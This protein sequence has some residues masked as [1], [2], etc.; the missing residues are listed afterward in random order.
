MPKKAVWFHPLKPPSEMSANVFHITENYAKRYKVKLKINL[1][2][3]TCWLREVDDRRI[4]YIHRIYSLLCLVFPII[5]ISVFSPAIWILPRRHYC[6][7]YPL[8][9]LTATS[10]YHSSHVWLRKFNILFGENFAL[11]MFLFAWIY[12]KYCMYVEQIEDE[13][14]RVKNYIFIYG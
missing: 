7:W 6:L 9:G 14:K 12:I 13:K 10:L 11:Y 3:G 8:Y 2:N 1:Y 5:H 4:K